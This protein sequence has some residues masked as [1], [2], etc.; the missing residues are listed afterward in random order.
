[1][2][3][4]NYCGNCKHWHEI[5]EHPYNLRLGRCDKIPEGTYGENCDGEGYRFPGEVFEDELYSEDFECFE[6]KD[7]DY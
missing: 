3:N 5:E 4:Y 2:D 6:E 1:M 7:D